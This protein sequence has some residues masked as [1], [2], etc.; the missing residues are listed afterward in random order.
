MMKKDDDGDEDNGDDDG[1]KLGTMDMPQVS[2][3]TACKELRGGETGI[4]TPLD[5]PGQRTRR[6]A[7]IVEGVC[8]FVCVGLSRHTGTATLAAPQGR[9][10]GVVLLPPAVK[11]LTHTPA[12]GWGGLQGESLSHTLKFTRKS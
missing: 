9:H 10:S 5:T 2:A 11:L 6:G 7:V 3:G 8:V 4:I 12:L 1:I